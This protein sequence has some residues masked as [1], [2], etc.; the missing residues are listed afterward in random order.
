MST[1]HPNVIFKIALRKQLWNAFGTDTVDIEDAAISFKMNF[2]YGLK[3]IKI[4]L[5]PAPDNSLTI[6]LGPP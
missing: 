3:L 5:H 1:V 6:P 4:T 2:T